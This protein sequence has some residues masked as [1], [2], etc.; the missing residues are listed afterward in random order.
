MNWIRTF[1]FSVSLGL[2]NALIMSVLVIR[3]VS[4]I[5]PCL[6]LFI[7]IYFCVYTVV[8]AV[9]LIFE[10]IEEIEEEEDE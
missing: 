7:P 3:D 1:I 10:Y 6:I 8:D 5:L 9:V 4:F 2:T